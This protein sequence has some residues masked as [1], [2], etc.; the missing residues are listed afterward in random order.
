MSKSTVAY[1]VAWIGVSVLAAVFMLYPLSIGP[2]A[3][4]LRRDAISE[5][6]LF[7]IYAP[8]IWIGRASPTAA[9]VIGSYVD[10]WDG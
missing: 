7:T 10:L 1:R 6:T 2:A 8:L 9:L 5:E 4:L 3:W